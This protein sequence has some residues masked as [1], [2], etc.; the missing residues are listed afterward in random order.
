[1]THNSQSFLT[2]IRSGQT[3]AWWALGALALSGL[4]I[5]LDA[6]VL[7]I[8]LPELSTSLHASTGSLQWFS[9]AY[10]LVVGVAMLPASNLGDRFG[11]KRFLVGSLFLFGA[12]S[13]WCAL[14]TSTGELIAA[15][16]VLGLA[17]AAL[18]PLGF[19]MLPILFPD[20]DKRA[21]AVTMWTL[22]SALGLPLGPIVGG[23][24][25]DH[26]W[27]GSVFILNVPLCVVGAIALIMFL[28]ESRSARPV[29]LDV[30]G[31]LL[32]SI[33]LGGLIFGFIEAD[34][35]GWAAPVTWIPIIVGIALLT[36]FI[37]WEKR[38]THPLVELSLFEHRGFTWGTIQA[39]IANFALFGLLFAV[40]QYFQSIDGT[41]PLGTG[42]RLLPMIGGM[43]VG[44]QT[45]ARLVKKIGTGLAI[46]IG[47]L[48]T[49]ASLGIAATTTISTSY[50]FAAAWIAV[51]G[52]GI[53]LALPAAMTAAL[54]ALSV[55]R[56]GA[57]SGLIQAVR[58]VGGTVG[59]AVLGTV[60]GSGYRSR[61]DVGH[62]SI[63]VANTVRESVSAGIEVGRQLHDETLI[64]SVQVAFDHGMN[65]TLLVSG[66]L[67]FIGAALALV[68]LPRR[69]APK[70]PTPIEPAPELIHES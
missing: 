53:G 35:K 45:S 44:T 61:V 66:I 34:T 8:A 70:E 60:L 15:R 22:A 63:G 10:T 51:L 33:G 29:A 50:G 5:G 46:T 57:G 32:S 28:P 59:V 42:I 3:A 20:K 4:T 21:K 12:A 26:F 9:T 52:L 49:A 64:R 11:R 16:A 69:P 2:R 47:F 25:L 58:Q 31:T 13:L 56:A 55:E 37:R 19:A 17:G 41:T 40:P 67:V 7:N 23:W 68:F 27:W 30:P 54:S 62:L 38:S 48:L 24:L 39:T 6:T 36:A 18:L 14:S 43:L 65:L 1:M